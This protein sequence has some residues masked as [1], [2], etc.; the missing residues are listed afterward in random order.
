MRAAFGEVES[1]A[2]A[3]N[4]EKSLLCHDQTTGMSLDLRWPK[5]ILSLEKD[6][7]TLKPAVWRVT[8]DQ[9][10]GWHVKDVVVII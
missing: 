4:C 2:S 3:W 8:E 9:N 7:T 5:P 1:P 10:E 6:L